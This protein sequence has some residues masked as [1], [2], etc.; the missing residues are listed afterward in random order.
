[1]FRTLSCSCCFIVPGFSN[2]GS[3]VLLSSDYMLVCKEL[4]LS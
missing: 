4:G 1:M 3:S 2:V